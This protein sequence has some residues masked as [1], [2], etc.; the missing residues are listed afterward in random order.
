M[1]KKVRTGDRKY[2]VPRTVLCAKFLDD[3]TIS[4]CIV[5]RPVFARSFITRP[6]FVARCST[7]EYFSKLRQLA[8][9][10]ILQ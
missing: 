10:I 7:I 2:Y 9:N 6:Q 5:C 8:Y 1:K 4:R 3:F